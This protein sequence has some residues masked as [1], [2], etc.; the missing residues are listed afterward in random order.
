ML[1]VDSQIT[2]LDLRQDI[3]IIQGNLDPEN[4]DYKCFP[5]TDEEDTLVC[6]GFSKKNA[7]RGNNRKNEKQMMNAA[8]P[9]LDEHQQQNMAS[10]PYITPGECRSEGSSD[11][12]SFKRQFNM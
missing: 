3:M 11:Y 10:P 5:D 1:V 12:A 2:Y 6:I 7:Q 8:L 9:I 4:Y